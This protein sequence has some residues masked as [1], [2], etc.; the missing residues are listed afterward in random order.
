MTLPR[1]NPARPRFAVALACLVAFLGFVF[2]GLPRAGAG[3][4]IV[5][6]PKVILWSVLGGTIEAEGWFASLGIENESTSDSGGGKNVGQIHDGDWANYAITVGDTV[7][8]SERYL[9]EARVASATSGGTIT[10]TVDGTEVGALAVSGTGGWQSWST[11]STVVEIEDLSEVL[12][13]SYSG[14]DGLLMNLNWLRFQRAP[15]PGTPLPTSDPLPMD[16]DEHRQLALEAMVDALESYGS[17]AGTFMVAGGGAGGRGTGW[18][19]Y[20]ETGS[21][22]PVSTVALL[23]AGGHMPAD[24]LRDPLWTDTLSIVGDVL[25]YPCKDRVAVFTRE[26]D[27]QPTAED[28]TWWTD[29]DCHR[30]P[31]DRLGATHYIVSS[32][33]P[34]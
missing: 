32:P 14:N 7:G 26:G 23:I 8:E 34:G 13:L 11:V 29:N 16:E 18:A 27:G 17:Q 31:I 1:H 30:Y 24:A 19:F 33:L 4:T 12:T 28:G 5:H 21:N 25:V 2:S 15:V 10:M 9:V 22:Y 6:A 3:T 20:E